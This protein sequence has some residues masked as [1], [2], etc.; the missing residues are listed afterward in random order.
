MEGGGSAGAFAIGDAIPI[1][2]R[3]PPPGSATGRGGSTAGGDAG[4]DTGDGI[5]GMPIIVPFN[6]FAGAGA[7]G[8][9][10]TLG[11]M[12]TMVLFIESPAGDAGRG[13]GAFSVNPSS[14]APHTPQCAAGAFEDDPQRGQTIIRRAYHVEVAAWPEFE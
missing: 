8:G 3:F 10:A 6:G 7:L 13:A 12:P 5:T 14:D 9:G 2:V 4:P 1:M 11:A